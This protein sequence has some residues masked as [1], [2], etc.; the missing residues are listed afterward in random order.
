MQFKNRRR[1]NLGIAKIDLLAP[2]PPNFGTLVDLR[3]KMLENRPEDAL[4]SL[5]LTV[6]TDLAGLSV[7][8]VLTVLTLLSVLTVFTV[9]TIFM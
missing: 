1:Q 6:L 8:I 9:L 5:V 7:L 3:T 4:G 2:P